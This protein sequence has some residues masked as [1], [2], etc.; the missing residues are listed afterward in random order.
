M[1][2]QTRHLVT[3]DR[4]V[5]TATPYPVFGS[6]Y[7]FDR[8]C[9][10]LRVGRR[11]LG[12]PVEKSEIPFSRIVAVSGREEYTP[13][14][15]AVGDS[16][17]SP[18]RYNFVMDISIRKPAWRGQISILICEFSSRFPSHRLS[19][20][21][22]AKRDDDA[23]QAG[24]RVE[25]IGQEI[26]S[27]VDPDERRRFR[28]GAE[29]TLSAEL[30]RIAEEMLQRVQG[31]PG[32]GHTELVR[33]VKGGRLAKEA[34]VDQLLRDNKVSFITQGGNRKYSVRVPK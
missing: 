1:T 13:G 15:E 32:I 28:L 27:V 17:G 3:R 12:I 25:G 29:N 11:F 33:R 30:K 26:M 4:V 18:D 24:Q 31:E 22:A 9:Q 21:Q 23:I 6:R 14:S 5:I 10:V 19:A 7:V 8:S 2:D 34:A 16:W 20:K